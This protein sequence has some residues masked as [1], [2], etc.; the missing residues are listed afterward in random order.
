MGDAPSEFA[1]LVNE[2]LSMWRCLILL[3][4]KGEQRCRGW[5]S[6]ILV[7]VSDVL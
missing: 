1:V 7:A 6:R 4:L 5:R 3:P 2:S